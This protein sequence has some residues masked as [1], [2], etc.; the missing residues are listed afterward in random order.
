[1]Y[2]S[3]RGKKDEERGIAEVSFSAIWLILLDSQHKQKQAQKQMQPCHFC[4]Q[5]LTFYKNAGGDGF[6][7]FLF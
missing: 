4:Y 7:D 5:L 1:M 6:N 3:T 2:S